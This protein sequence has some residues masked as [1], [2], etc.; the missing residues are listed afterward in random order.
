MHFKNT[1]HLNKL[2]IPQISQ[3]L[4]NTT[5]RSSKVCIVSCIKMCVLYAWRLVRVK[6]CMIQALWIDVNGRVWLSLDAPMSEQLKIILRCIQFTAMLFLYCSLC[7]TECK[8]SVAWSLFEDVWF[9][10]HIY[11]LERLLSALLV[12]AIMGLQNQEV[13]ICTHCLF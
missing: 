6:L 10:E 8:I 3:T 4:V 7:T 13:A 1:H 5:V 12:T 2:L 9:P 11:R